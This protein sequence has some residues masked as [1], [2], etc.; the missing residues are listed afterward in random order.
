MIRKPVPIIL[1]HK[2]GKLLFFVEH[3]YVEDMILVV[4]VAWRLDGFLLLLIALYM[5]T[6][7]F[8]GKWYDFLRPNVEIK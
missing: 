6:L 1:I 8:C 4:E 5:M 2:L 7:F 3:K